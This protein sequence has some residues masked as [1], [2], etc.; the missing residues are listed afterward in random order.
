[1]FGMGAG[2]VARGQRPAQIQY[3]TV[4]A[5][6]ILEYLL[7]EQLTLSISS[8]VP[9]RGKYGSKKSFPHAELRLNMKVIAWKKKAS[10]KY[11]L[12]HFIRD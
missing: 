7:R 3:K 6:A 2:G 4:A 11:T 1:M 10:K 12:I 9:W 8:G 5:I